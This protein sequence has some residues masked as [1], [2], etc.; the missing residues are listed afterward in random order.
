MGGAEPSKKTPNKDAFVAQTPNP[1]PPTSNPKTCTIG[2]TVCGTN[3]NPLNK[4][5]T[6]FVIDHT[7]EVAPL[8]SGDPF[9]DVCA[10]DAP[11]GMGVHVPEVSL[12]GVKLVMSADK[13]VVVGIV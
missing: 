10:S 3:P 2:G 5:E 11:V 6:C 13:N 8:L 4:G 7:C 1:Q 9:A 12:C